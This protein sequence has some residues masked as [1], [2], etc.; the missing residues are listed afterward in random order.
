MLTTT[1][2]G[3]HVLACRIPFRIP[4]GPATGID[5]FVFA[6][7]LRGEGAVVIDTG[8]AGSEGAIVDV[9]AETGA[10]QLERILLTHGHVDHVGS[11]RALKERT[12]A[13]VAAHPAER[14]WIEDIDRQA[15]ERPVPGFHL[16]ADRSVALDALLTDG[17]HLDL[18]PGLTL[19]VLH[20]PGHSPGSTSFLLEEEGILFTG[21]AVPVPGDLPVYDDALE[22]ARSVARLSELGDV[23]VLLSAWDEPRQGE[24]AA[25]ALAAGAAVI[26]SV[27]ETV[28]EISAQG[29]YDGCNPMDLTRRTVE[30]LGLPPS[31]A[32][33][34]VTRTVIGHWRHRERRALLE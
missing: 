17:Q 29:A 31:F 16:L 8:V 34:M 22:S 30:C 23:R 26:A 27:H 10:G 21:D 13:S 18:G 25:R 7:V 20:T 11:A 5:R 12:G 9:I 3:S 14:H 1:A 4:T 2:I 15:R 32:N 28:R 6:F 24:S 19:R 33:P